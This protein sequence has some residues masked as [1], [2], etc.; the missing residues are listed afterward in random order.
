MKNNIFL[1]LLLFSIP[2][3][4]FGFCDLS[5]EEIQ[6]LKKFGSLALA[7]FETTCNSYQLAVECIKNKIPGDFVECGVFAGAQCAA[8]AFAS[9]KFNAN[10]TIHLWDS[11]VN[12]WHYSEQ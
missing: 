5:K 6:N 2:K 3:F 7:K 12:E 4:A 11:S 8:M 1:I 9:L 10:K